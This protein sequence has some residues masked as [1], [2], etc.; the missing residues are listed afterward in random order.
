MNAVAYTRVSTEEQASSGAGLNAQLDV[1]KS[2]CSRRGL[3]LMSAYSDEG[4]S[5]ATGFEK[6]PGLLQA[7]SELR[8]GDLLVVAKRDRL[9]RD[10]IVVALIEASVSR[11]GAKVV[12]AAGEGTE[13][14]EPS[15]ILMRR[16]IDAFSEYER[17]II[18]ART[19]SAL[20]AKKRRGERVG[21]IA[22]GYQLSPDLRH[23]IQNTKEQRTLTRIREL[24]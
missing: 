3:V 24:R 2:Y 16:L 9:G 15:S 11:K 17:L 10:P 13:T 22:F 20:Q 18:T 5:G 7:V 19:K 12:S 21:N 4:I 23:L 14:D 1:C 6:R 8:R